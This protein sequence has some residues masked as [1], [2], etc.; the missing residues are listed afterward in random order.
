MHKYN[1][2]FPEDATPDSLTADRAT[3]LK[4]IMG[5]IGENAFIEPPLNI[6]YGCNISIGKDFYSNFKY[7][8]SETHAHS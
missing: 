1:N 4:Q 5:S 8:L 3:L 6:D 2:H 7:V